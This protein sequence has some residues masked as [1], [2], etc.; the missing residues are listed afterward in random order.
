[1][2]L[3][4]NERF[5]SNFKVK[6]NLVIHMKILLDDISNGNFHEEKEPYYLVCD[7]YNFL[8]CKLLCDWYNTGS[9]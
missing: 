2:S 1:M 5:C 4:E 3:I 6:G 9:Q 8:V 7:W